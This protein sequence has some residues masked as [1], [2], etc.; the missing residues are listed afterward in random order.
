V[1]V[2]FGA[3]RVE[4]NVYP[5]GGHWFHA[6]NGMDDAVNFLSRHVHPRSDEWMAVV[7]EQ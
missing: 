2:R 4:W 1:L 5:D 6:E 3:Q 7:G